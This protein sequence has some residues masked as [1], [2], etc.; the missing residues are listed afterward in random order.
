M[1]LRD[2]L[3]DSTEAPIYIETVPKRGY[4]FIAPVS[5]SVVLSD[6]I[7]K[8]EA[9]VELPQNEAIVAPPAANPVVVPGSHHRFRVMVAM[10]GILLIVVTATLV[11][12]RT[13]PCCPGAWRQQGRLPA[14]A[15]IP[16]LPR[17]A[18]S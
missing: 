10:F 2:A 9:E 5:A 13:R 15:S 7:A 6:Q 14:I 17:A 3:G 4:R 18:V 1:K 12:L 11:F 8:A 16:S